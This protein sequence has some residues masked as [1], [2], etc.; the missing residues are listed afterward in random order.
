[1]TKDQQLKLVLD[2]TNWS[3]GFFPQESDEH[4]LYVYATTARPGDLDET[5]VYE[6]LKAYLKQE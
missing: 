5:E 3:G 6:F 2:F 4:T 1:M